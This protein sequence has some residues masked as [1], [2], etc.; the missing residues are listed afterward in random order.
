M[1]Y[2]RCAVVK[3]YGGV[4]E[5]FRI[6]NLHILLKK[7]LTNTYCILPPSREGR[8][9]PLKNTIFFFFKLKIPVSLVIFPDQ[10][11]SLNVM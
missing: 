2:A 1:W 6:I 9:I 10:F 8:D 7:N 5:W 11:P 4:M 3:W